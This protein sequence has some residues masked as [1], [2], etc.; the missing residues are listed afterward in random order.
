MDKEFFINNRKKLAEKLEDGSLLLLFAGKA[1]RRSADEYYEF[2]PNRNF[3]YLTG[4]NIEKAVFLMSKN[5][6]TVKMNLFI[7]EPDSFKEKWTGKMMEK[8][9]ASSISGIEDILYLDSFLGTVK[10]TIMGGCNNV[11]LDIEHFDDWEMPL[12][13]VQTY[14]RDLKDRFPYVEIK[15][16]HDMISGLRVIK[17]P[18]EIENMK[19]ALEITKEGI[20]SM[21]DNARP[22]MMEYELEAYFDHALKSRGVKNPAF[23]TIAASGVN[24]AVLHY[25][26]NNSKTGESDLILFDLGAEYG[27]YSADISRTFP[28]SGKFTKRQREVYDVV[29]EA[30]NETTKA[31]KPGVPFKNLNELTKGI[32]TKGLYRLGLIKEDSELSKYY[33]HGVSHYLGLD[34]HDVGSRD[35]ELAPGM[36]LTVEPGLYIEEEGI[37]VRIEDDVLV[38]D[39]GYE[40]LSKEIIRT[41]DEIEEYMKNRAV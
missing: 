37:G 19:K 13:L 1:P 35:M 3:Y 26:R 22:G 7:E 9:T 16:I 21:M 33:Y 17:A 32:L 23:K 24:G 2:T 15:N 10:G 41:A 25:S 34:T 6:G 12:S 31:I 39:E 4:I 20:L 14:A 38:T 11:Y 8:I 27:Y 5:K 40:V 28:L 18:E 29:L 30:L 36:V